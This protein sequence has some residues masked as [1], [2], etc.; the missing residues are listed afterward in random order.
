MYINRQIINQIQRPLKRGK[1][2]LLLGARQTG[3]STLLPHLNLDEIISLVTPQNR[4]YYEKTP[5]ALTQEMESLNQKLKRKPRVAIDEVQK[6]PI[7]MDAIQ[8]LIDRNI[9]QF[10][11]SG[12]SARKLKKPS[13]INLLP[14]RVISFRLD[15]ITIT[16]YPDIEDIKTLLFYGSLPEIMLCKNNDEKELLLSSYVSTYLEEEIRLEALTRNIGAF[17]RFLELAAVMSGHLINTHK[18]AQEI[19]IARSTVVEY[20]QILEDCLIAERIMPLSQTTKRRRLVKTPKYLLYDMGVRRFCANE[21]TQPPEKHL[22]S[23][24]EQWVGLE[25]IRQ[26]RMLSPTAKIYFWRDNNGPEID[27]VLTHNEVFTPIEVKW[28]TNPKPT[29]I[30]HLQLFLEEYP[31]AKKGYLICRIPRPRQITPQ[32]IAL[33]WKELSEIMG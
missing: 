8:D 2:V 9:A 22:G 5:E 13:K 10:V 16:E 6:V 29:D 20:F 31:Q 15:P 17:S 26:A 33:P 25:L 7:L 30:R 11:L 24:F 23:L 14:G 1:S 32:I 18:I 12:S 27:W 28:T 3:K 4:Q 21:G 19:G